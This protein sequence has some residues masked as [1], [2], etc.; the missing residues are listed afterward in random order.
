MSRNPAIEPVGPSMVI[1]GDN[2]GPVWPLGRP[3]S[4]VSSGGIGK[5]ARSEKVEH[6]ILLAIDKDADFYL[7]RP[8]GSVALVGCT[9]CRFTDSDQPPS[10][11]NGQGCHNC[12]A[13]KC[14][15]TTY[16]EVCDKW[17]PEPEASSRQCDECWKDGKRVCPHKDP[18]HATDENDNTEAYNCTDF[19]ECPF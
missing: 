19:G 2:S 9:S 18:T 14:P 15:K 4:W 10:V 11:E 13:S 5:A 6:G 3:V 7:E 8:D 12:L 17:E 16:S 1:S